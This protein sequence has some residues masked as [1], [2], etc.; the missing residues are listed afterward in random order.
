MKHGLKT[1]VS[2]KKPHENRNILNGNKSDTRICFA[3]T[4][5]RF[6]ETAR[7]VLPAMWLLL[8]CRI[9]AHTLSIYH[10]F[11]PHVENQPPNIP[12]S[13]AHYSWETLPPSQYVDTI[14]PP[15]NQVALVVMKMA[16]KTRKPGN[17]E[18]PLPKKAFRGDKGH[19]FLPIQ[20]TRLATMRTCTISGPNH[21]FKLRLYCSEEP[22]PRPSPFLFSCLCVTIQL[23]SCD[24]N[25]LAWQG[26]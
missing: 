22:W 4:H 25:I 13:D 8:I 6:L 1:L 20:S 24:H 15:S 5:Y 21:I 26:T 12:P 10:C 19:L 11:V 16:K 2:I 14:R 23:S 3:C 9:W 18:I 17:I 7:T